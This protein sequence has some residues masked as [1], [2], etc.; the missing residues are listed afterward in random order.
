MK[1]PYYIVVVRYDGP[2]W[3]IHFGDYDRDTANEE[4]EAWLDATLLGRKDAQVVR[5]DD[6]TQDAINAK[7]KE[8]N[9]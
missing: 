7:L 1:T 4:R 5:V 8:L 2:V 9:A 6:D 3:E